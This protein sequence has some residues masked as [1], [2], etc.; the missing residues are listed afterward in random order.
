MMNCNRSGQLIILTTILLLSLVVLSAS[1]VAA[2]DAGDAGHHFH[3]N[4]IGLY[5]GSTTPF[6]EETGGQTA[7]AIGIEYERRFSPDV[8]ALLMV[9]IV[10]GRE[11]CGCRAAM[12][13]PQIATF[14][15]FPEH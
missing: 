11:L 7:P 9:Q 2:T 15:Q 4:D 1:P 14:G 5:I 8:G 6:D 12:N 3:H 13:A 10:R